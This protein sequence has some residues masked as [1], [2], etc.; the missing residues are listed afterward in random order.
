M[1]KKMFNKK[2]LTSRGEVVSIGKLKMEKLSIFL[3][4]FQ[5]SLAL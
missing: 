2:I 3:T 4:K 1:I 5:N